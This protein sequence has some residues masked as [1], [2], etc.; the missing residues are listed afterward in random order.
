MFVGLTYKEII[1]T[2]Q[3]ME[4]EHIENLKNPKPITDISYFRNGLFVL[5]DL[6][7]RMK[8]QVIKKYRK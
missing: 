8:N 7:K 5:R 6:K 1:E 3:E 2:I 4:A